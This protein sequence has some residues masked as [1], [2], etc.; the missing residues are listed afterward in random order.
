M[1]G[2]VFV[3]VRE[4]AS[5]AE[6][7]AEAF[8]AAG[9]S[10][11]GSDANSE[12][13]SVVLWSRAAQRSPA[14]QRAAE[15][16]LRAGKA[17]IASL[18]APPSREH[19]FNAPVVDLSGWSGEDG[20][21]LDPLFDAA[22]RIAHAARPDVIVLPA[23]PVYEDAQ[24]TELPLQIASVEYERANRRS[25]E[26]P[27]PTG[28]L[29]PMRGEPPQKLGAPS[30]RRDFRRM[31]RRRPNARAHAAVAFAV[32]ALI[33][34]GVFALSANPTPEAAPVRTAQDG[35]VQGGSV[36]LTSAS[37]GAMGLEDVAP[38]ESPPLF[39]PAPQ[40]GHA[41]LEPPSA[42]TIRR[43]AYAPRRTQRDD[44]AAYQAPVLIPESITADLDARA[45][46]LVAE[47]ANGPRS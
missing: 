12:A 41:G 13:L 11:T 31:S 40:R 20:A 22:D 32:I 19:V 2:V 25:W 18:A 15:Q 5:D 37:A 33:G 45:P 43:A 10:I 42:R 14:F 4:D 26:A 35:G 6:T 8:D 44:R 47:H 7:L 1:A 29:R 36:S 39:E 34:G 24:F 46:V 16:A 21:A 38:K 27:I 3:F 23:R 9:Y 30:P 28:M 17:I